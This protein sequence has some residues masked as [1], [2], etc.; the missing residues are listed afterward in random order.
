MDRVDGRGSWEDLQW[1]MTWFMGGWT[2]VNQSGMGHRAFETHCKRGRK[3]EEPTI[4]Q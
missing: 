3:T 1:W 4:N 2:G